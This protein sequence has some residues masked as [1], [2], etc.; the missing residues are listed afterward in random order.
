MAALRAFKVGRRVLS[1]AQLQHEPAQ[2]F[3]H[4]PGSPEGK[5]LLTTL[6]P[7]QMRQRY[8]AWL[9]D[10]TRQRTS[11][12]YWNAPDDSGARKMRAV[13][14][15]LLRHFFDDVAFDWA[16]FVADTMPPLDAE[17]KPRFD[18]RFVPLAVAKPTAADERAAAARKVVFG[19]APRG[20]QTAQTPAEVAA[21]CAGASFTPVKREK[22]EEDTKASAASPPAPASKPKATAKPKAT[23]KPK[24]TAK[25]KAD[26]ARRSTTRTVDAERVLP[27]HARAFAASSTGRAFAVM[28][29]APTAPSR[30]GTSSA[31]ADVAA[32]AATKRVESNE[33]SGLSVLA[34]YLPHPIG[35]SETGDV[36]RSAPVDGGFAF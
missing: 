6:S 7:A 25:A 16:S 4:P 12:L 36:C 21:R 33:R 2:P 18:P 35:I 32:A 17:G 24:M 19:A 22:E 14:L 13:P 26:A 27:A 10:A 3:P 11:L 1:G 31:N 30:A 5:M 29:G 20:P 15:S 23:P 28:D 34:L 8:A 9:D